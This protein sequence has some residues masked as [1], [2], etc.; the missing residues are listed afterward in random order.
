MLINEFQ[1]RTLENEYKVKI[2]SFKDT[3]SSQDSNQKITI[4][5]ES[6][7]RKITVEMWAYIRNRET[8]YQKAE[9][10]VSFKRGYKVIKTK[11]YDYVKKCSIEK[12]DKLLERV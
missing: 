2:L 12:E 7:E 5:F 1:K 11:T 10:M 8:I 3:T 9:E 6:L 4:Q